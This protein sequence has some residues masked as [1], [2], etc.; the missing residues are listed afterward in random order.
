MTLLRPLLTY[1]VGD[2]KSCR[3]ALAVMFAAGAL[4]ESIA[5]AEDTSSNANSK[6]AQKTAIRFNRDVRPILSDKCFVCH[7]PDRNQRQADLRLDIREGL[8]GAIDAESDAEKRSVVVPGKPQES[9]LIRRIHAEGDERMPP[10]DAG[11]PLSAREREILERWVAEGAVFEGHWSFQPLVRPAVPVVS[12]GD[13]M[14]NPIDAF[15]QSQWEADG[16]APVAPADRVTLMRRVYFDLLGLP[17]ST[18][19]VDEFVHDADVDAFEK[20]VERILSSPHFGERMAVQWLDAVRYADTVGYHGDQEREV[21]SYRD[22]VINAFNE[23]MPFDQFTQEQLAGDLLPG[24]TLWQKVASS[25]NM[26]GMTTI[27]GGAQEKEYLAKYAADR[28]RT[29]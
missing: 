5:R 25:Y 20:V 4:L 8:F 15:L 28:V 7:G 17:P 1:F 11:K 26:L 6:P 19:E 27:E 24:S 29:T 9:E 13:A 21:S 2:T 16:V 18:A 22:Y 3:R 12:R 14:G 10:A 23:N